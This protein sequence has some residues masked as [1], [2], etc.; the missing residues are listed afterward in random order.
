M[1]SPTRRDII[2]GNLLSIQ[3]WAK[4]GQDVIEVPEKLERV[5]EAL[6]KYTN[7]LFLFV[8]TPDEQGKAWQ[9]WE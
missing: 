1:T 2:N 5:A 3:G 4:R 7:E 6:L 9:W 8:H